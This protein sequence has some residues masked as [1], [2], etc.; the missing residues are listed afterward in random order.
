MARSG[1]AE[2]DSVDVRGL[3]TAL[4]LGGA[5]LVVSSQLAYPALSDSRSRW[6]LVLSAM[7]LG[8]FLLGAQ[9]TR[10]RRLPSAIQ[11]VTGPTARYFGLSIAQLALLSLSLPNAL[12]AT[13][14][15][16]RG[17]HASHAGVALVAWLTAISLVVAGSI[18]RG[19]PRVSLERRDALL[20]GSLFLVALALRATATADVPSTF[21]GDEGSVGLHAG[22]FLDGE[23]DNVLGL[24]WFSF[25][26]LHFAIQSVSIRV[27][28]QTVEALRLTSALAGA[29]TVVAVY[30]LGRV[31]FGRT[32]GLAAALTLAVSHFHIHMSRIGLNNVWDGFFGTVA[33]ASL[34][35]GWR[36]GRRSA[37]VL[38][39]LAL[40]LGQYFYASIRVLPFVV[41]VWCAVAW[42]QRDR[43]RNRMPDLLLG[44]FT[45]V[46]AYL[47]L[48]LL[49]AQHRDEFAAPFNRV[50]IFANPVGQPTGELVRNQLLRGALGF[51]HEPLRGIYNPG[52]PLLRPAMAAL[53]LLGLVLLMRQPDLRALLLVLPLV[54]VVATGAASLDAPASQR[55]IMAMPMCA[56]IVALPL[57]QTAAW[58][59]QLWPPRRALI[60]AG[61]VAV[62]VAVA[63]ADLRYYFVDVSDGPYV[64][65]GQNTLVATEIAE[66][67]RDSPDQIQRVHFFGLPRM[68]YYSLSTIPYLNPQIEGIDTAEPTGERRRWVADEATRFVFLPER[69]AELAEV[70]ESYPGG[71]IEERH[72]DGTLLFA[73]YDPLPDE[74]AR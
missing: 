44:G 57:V 30:W 2:V 71:S 74:G 24:G 17:L 66:Y 56:V 48:G 46:I 68:G 49:F 64:L 18:H 47:P 70:R 40:G 6:A 59:E 13:L 73:V 36:T 10:L 53:F 21:S 28:G 51:T 39:G 54:A 27:F 43:F 63:A 22:M 62:L 38:C 12:L 41:L 35:H 7:G 58:L 37:F 14:A 5:A 69:L 20:S 26:A 1:P 60:L 9:V 11:R 61:A 52:T 8:C 32:A 4:L 50:S 34:W 55:Y 31:M 16:G 19:Q 23:T 25:P 3:A 72:R 29:L 67:L 42:W 15:A 45:A 33:I 65:G